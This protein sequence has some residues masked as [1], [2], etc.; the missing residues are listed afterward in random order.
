MDVS[1]KDTLYHK[2]KSRPAPKVEKKPRIIDNLRLAFWFFISSASQH[3]KKVVSFNKKPSVSYMLLLAHF[4]SPKPIP[5]HFCVQT[6]RPLFARIYISVLN[7]TY[8]TRHA[9]MSVNTCSHFVFPWA[10]FYSSHWTA[11]LELCLPK[12]PLVP[13]SQQ[14][15]LLPQPWLYLPSPA[16]F[17]CVLFN[18]PSQTWRSR[19]S[20][21]PLAFQAYGRKFLAIFTWVNSV[22][23]AK[24][25]Q[26]GR[27]REENRKKTPKTTFFSLGKAIGDILGAEFLW[28]PH[29][30]CD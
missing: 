11:T 10:L 2:V 24:K 26:R 6:S 14:R 20:G 5:L 25:E 9:C 17:S 22:L 12:L 29:S 15:L 18:C 3:S 7:G 1:L 4:A 28:L 23:Q 13:G 27:E 8:I 16:P 19:A 30:T 21:S